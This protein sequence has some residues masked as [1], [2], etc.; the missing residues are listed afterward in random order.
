MSVENQENWFHN[1]PWNNHALRPRM[2][3]LEGNG[4]EVLQVSSGS[5]G[6]LIYGS[7]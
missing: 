7:T 1:N 5:M 6:Q 2:W 4:I 3:K